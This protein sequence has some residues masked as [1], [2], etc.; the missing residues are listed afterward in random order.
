MKIKSVLAGVMLTIL[1]LSSFAETSTIITQ[2]TKGSTIIDVSNLTPI[3]QA[4][5]SKQVAQKE[6]QN[7]QTERVDN[8]NQD[9]E[10]MILLL[11]VVVVFFILCFS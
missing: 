9:L 4:E 11:I 1:S 2:E 3:Q 5:I 6:D 7:R 10:T 8:R